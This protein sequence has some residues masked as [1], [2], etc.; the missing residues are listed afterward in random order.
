[1]KNNDPKATPKIA[2][3]W[4]QDGSETVFGSQVN[5]FLPRQPLARLLR[6]SWGV[7]ESSWGGLGWSNTS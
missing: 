1:M 3:R 4:L 2:P 7:W 5:F 6:S